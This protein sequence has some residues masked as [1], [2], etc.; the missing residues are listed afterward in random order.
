MTTKKNKDNKTTSNKS[1]D[2][3]KTNNTSASSTNSS[4]RPIS[5]KENTVQNEK[6]SRKSKLK[7]LRLNPSENY[8][9]RFKQN[10]VDESLTDFTQGFYYD[11]QLNDPYL[12]ISLHANTEISESGEWVKW[13]G[14]TLEP[15]GGE[16]RGE[17]AA[18]YGVT[19]LARSIMSEDLSY[20]VAN[21]F[22][23]FS[24]G[25]PIEGLFNT[26]KPYA[27]V[28]GKFGA[29]LKEATELSKNSG[30][31]GS[32]LVGAINKVAGKASEL[33]SGVGNYLNKALMIQ[34][35][36]FSYYNGTEFNF[37][38]MEMKFIVFSDYVHDPNGGGYYYKFQSAEDYLKK[39]QPYVMGLY[40]PFSAD[41]L[42]NTGLQGDAKKFISD[43]VGFQDPPGGFTCD[44]KN[45][46]N[47]L[48]GTVRLNFGSTWAIDNLVIKNMNVTLSK[49]QAKHPDKV[50][51]T[52]P[53]YAE[54][55]LSFA[56]ASKFVDT[57]YSNILGHSG[58][59]K[60]RTTLTS[61]YEKRLQ[62][63]TNIATGNTSKK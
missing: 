40:N 1:K 28:L 32:G 6:E 5:E 21:N 51:A 31:N 25:N 18:C 4:S 9:G 55:T 20:S 38:N 33:M 63:L 17:W 45:L 23:D 43:Y 10:K 46:N 57:D 37:N 2:T 39:L 56:P 15:I 29:N 59:E 41:F 44:T 60:I 42:Q 12:S 11:T 62:E 7:K 14:E 22:Q 13:S 26:F 19:P 35:T 27:P 61:S 53:L 52:V 8:T 58:L 54:V 30:N 24:G 47:C 48:K 36:R 50:G 34:G 49:V 3:S 16:D